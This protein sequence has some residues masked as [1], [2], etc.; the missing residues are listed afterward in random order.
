LRLVGKY[1]F[2]TVYGCINEIYDHAERMA[3]DAIRNMPA[4]TWT[5]IDFCDDNGIDR[6]VPLK[7]GVSVTIDPEEAEITFDYSESAE[8]QRGPMN[9][10]LIT[11][12]SISRMLG[13]ILTAPDSAACEGSFRPIKIVAPK[14]SVFN[15]HD[16]APTNLYGWPGMT[17]IEACMSAMA[18]DFPERL[19]AQSGGDLCAVFRYGF[20]PVTSEMWVEANIEGIGMGAS[21]FAD[22]ESAMVH[23]LEACSRNLPVE[24]EEAKDPELIER[25]ELRQDSGGAGKYRGG[26]G[27]QRDYRLLADGRMISVL[28][29]CIAPHAGVA[30]GLPGGRT[31][32][33]LDS[34]IYG[35]GFE[36]IKTPDQP[37]AKGDLLS[38]R[39]G[40]GGGFGNPLE[41]DPERVREDVLEELVSVQAAQELYGVVFDSDGNV[42]HED[43]SRVREKRLTAA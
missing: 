38:I 41:R 35:E 14:G 22:G 19:P 33:V 32:G 27:V 5:G 42:D 39:S 28:E 34:S 24:L 21:A 8:Q 10:P 25:Y 12:I 40:G 9:V 37:I 29:R 31:Y 18:P 36:I 4:G 11:A 20:D 30:G 13:K 23:I 1:G 15:P 2:D 3:R 6:G 43:T 7:V 16:A 26:L 17:A